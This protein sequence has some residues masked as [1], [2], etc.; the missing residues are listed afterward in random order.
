LIVLAINFIIIIILRKILKL[1][2]EEE[3]EVGSNHPPWPKMGG[4]VGLPPPRAWS[5]PHGWSTAPMA[6]GVV[7]PP[8]KD[9]KKKKKK[10][11]KRMGFGLL[12]VAG[13]PPW[14]WGG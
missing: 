6:K 3:I 1:E 4:P 14:A 13:L 11:M 9:K 2:E 12:R 8:Q 7:I 10:R 5:H